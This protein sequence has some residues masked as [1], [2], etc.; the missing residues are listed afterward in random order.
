MKWFDIVLFMG[1]VYIFGAILSSYTSQMGMKNISV[2]STPP[3]ASE[4]QQA[5]NILES[6]KSGIPVSST[7]PIGTALGWFYQ[8]IS[9]AV[10]YLFNSIPFVKYVFWLPIY[11]QA[12]GIP[13]EI[14]WGL[15]VVYGFIVAV[16]M[17]EALTGR[18]VER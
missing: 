2:Y 17:F 5:S 11:L 18:E 8:Q 14:S 6:T 13:S 12:A 1:I 7:D 9:N 15:F 3:S 16:A 10:S 4:V